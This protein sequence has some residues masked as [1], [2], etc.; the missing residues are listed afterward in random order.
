M[1][2]KKASKKEKKKYTQ[3]L[4][5]CYRTEIKV[6]PSNWKTAAASTK[7]NWLIW[8]RFYDPSNELFVL[9]I[10]VRGMNKFSSLEQ[11]QAETQILI[12]NEK[13]LIDVKNYNPIIKDYMLLVTPE[14]Q[15]DEV[16]E[17]SEDSP[18]N[19]ALQWAFDNGEIAEDTKVDVK[20]KLKYFK[21]AATKLKFDELPIMQVRRKHVRLILDQIGKDKLRTVHT[22]KKGNKKRGIWSSSLF[23][24]FVGNMGMLFGILDEY[25]VTDHNPCHGIKKKKSVK[26]IR[27]TLSNQERKIINETLYV[28]DYYFWRTLMI[29][30]HS[31]ARRKELLLVKA[32]D[33]DLEKLGY[34]TIIKKG[35]LYQEVFKPIKEIAKE[36]WQE[37]LSEAKLE[38]YL[39]SRGLKPG[40][41]SIRPENLTKRWRRKVKIKL[42]VKADM[43]CLKH[44][45]LTEMIDELTEVMNLKKAKETVIALSS[46]T[47]TAMLDNV[48]DVK[49]Q[50]RKDAIVRKAKNTFA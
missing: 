18:L 49:A 13:D 1:L 45:N 4:N 30:F 34:K 43:Y 24:H 37:V 39:F 48:Y 5:G 44:M 20:S 36:L 8:Y 38:Q 29:F 41:K 9:P 16:G 50:D 21:A 46:H 14:T 25:E 35:G 26:K 32:E 6:S 17:A 40:N 11:R 15:T 7:K 3:L 27:L 28:E 2:I 12:D 22:D 42:G 23:N 33:V 47:S 31:G 10:K 19:Y